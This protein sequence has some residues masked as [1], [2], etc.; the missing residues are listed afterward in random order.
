LPLSDKKTAGMDIKDSLSYKWFQEVWN[1]QN[2]AAID[3]MFAADGIAHG[4]GAEAVRGPDSFK[5]FFRTFI[6]DFSNIEVIVDDL[7]KEGDKEVARCSVT[8][9]HNSTGK[10]VSFGGVTI[11]RTENGKFVEAWNYFDFLSMTQQITG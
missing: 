6:N 9:R 3:E 7:I 11:N 10:D 5:P 8:A 2:E 1:K 4:L